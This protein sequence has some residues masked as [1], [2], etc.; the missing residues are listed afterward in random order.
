MLIDF[1][2]ENASPDVTFVGE[3]NLSTDPLDIDDEVRQMCEQN[4]CGYYGRNW[5]CPPYTPPCSTCR[6]ILS[7][8]THMI[9]VRTT[10]ERKDLFDI[11]EMASHGRAHGKFARELREKLR[12]IEGLDFMMLS[13]GGCGVCKE[14]TCPDEKCRFPKERMFS[15]ES[16]G[17]QITTFLTGHGISCRAGNDEQSYFLMV[18]FNKPVDTIS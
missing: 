6:M 17:I 16:Y 18:F 4:L 1:V 3:F 11:E 7:K 15:I 9:L 5:C 8:Y 13:A 12:G 10:F 2:K 14:C